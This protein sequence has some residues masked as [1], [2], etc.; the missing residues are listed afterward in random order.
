MKTIL[1]NIFRNKI[2]HFIINYQWQRNSKTR[3]QNIFDYYF[4]YNN[5]K[6]ITGLILLRVSD[7]KNG[8]SDDATHEIDNALTVPRGC[9]QFH[10]ALIDD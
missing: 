8:V 3:L 6:L 10:S 4:C 7:I 1:E 5:Q 9:V 2:L